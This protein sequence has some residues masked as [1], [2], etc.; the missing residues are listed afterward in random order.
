MPQFFKVE[1]ISKLRKVIIN[2][3]RKKNALN[4]QAYQE[5]SGKFIHYI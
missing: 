1:T 2:N 5:L 4:A 3:P